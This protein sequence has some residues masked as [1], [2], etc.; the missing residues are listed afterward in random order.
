MHDGEKA[1]RLGIER[2][3][4]K[5]RKKLDRLTRDVLAAE[6]AGM[7]YG[8]WKVLHP[9]TPDEDEEEEQEMDPDSVVVNCEYCGE[10]FVKSKNNQ[11]RKFCSANCQKNYNNKKRREKARQ[12]AIGQPAV[13]PICGVDFMADYQHRIY[14]S[15]ECFAEGQRRRAKERYIC[16]KEKQTTAKKVETDL[17]GV[18]MT[19]EHCGGKFVKFKNQKR[20]RFCSTACKNRF[21]SDE[22]AEKRRQEAAGRTAT[23]TVCGAT[24]TPANGNSK[25]CDGC[26]AEVHNRKNR[27]CYARKKEKQKKE[28]AE[29]GSN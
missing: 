2:T 12:E 23:C 8:K 24:F 3:P 13:C 25:Y 27:E 22:R 16:N 19:C 11:T 10:R 26:Q 29:N 14:C 18:T 5:K 20:R 4:R 21:Y 15:T 9:H 7:S 28:A 1:A 6:A 17:D